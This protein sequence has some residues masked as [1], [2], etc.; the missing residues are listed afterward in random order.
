MKRTIKNIFIVLVLLPTF[1]YSHNKIIYLISSPRSL[2]VAFTRMMQARGD[3]SIFHE[4][5]ECAFNTITWPDMAQKVYKEASP[6]TFDAA[7][8]VILQEALEKPVFVKEIVTGAKHFLMNDEA[9]VSKPQVYFVFLVRCPHAIITSFCKARLSLRPD[10]Q[11]PSDFSYRIGCQP[12]YEL[13]HFIQEK[14]VHPPLLILTEDLYNNPIQTVQAFCKHVDIPYD[15]KAMHW[16]DLGSDFDGSQAWHEYK[17]KDTVHRWH[18]NAIHSTGFARPAHYDS[19]DQGNPTFK[20]VKLDW[21]EIA[22][23][24]YEENMIYY[25]ALLTEFK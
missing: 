15:E 16:Q 21:Q 19:D 24:C 22:H 17:H 7:K 9:F 11:L 6:K 18:G 10:V 14:A 2:S 3:F 4:P 23:T 1:T 20:E 25:K 13:F 12:L 8:Q 5:C